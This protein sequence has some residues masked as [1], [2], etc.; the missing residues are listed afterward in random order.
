MTP[1]MLAI[2]CGAIG[3][4][5]LGAEILLPA[6]GLLGIL[7]GLAV[8]G[9]VV[10]CFMINQWLGGIVFLSLIVLTPFLW[11]GWVKI[12]PHTPIGRRLMLQPIRGEAHPSS[13]KIG[14]TGVAVSELRPTG[15]CAFADDRFEA[16]SEH[17]IIAAGR[18]VRVVALE[19]NRPTVRAV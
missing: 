8:L 13:L 16:V 15:V 18:P 12:W 14:Q 19:N 4:A 5:L 1:A 17:G 7:G 2:L 11:V 6:H 3:L 10:F 9:A